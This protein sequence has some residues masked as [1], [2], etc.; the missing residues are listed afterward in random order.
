MEFK[1]KLQNLRKQMN[2]TQEQLASLLYISRTAV[3]KWE[4]GKGYPN[5]DSLK[6]ISKL[7]NVTINDLLS[8]EEIVVATDLEKKQMNQQ[9]TIYIFIM[10]NFFSAL[11]AFVPI[12]SNYV[13]DVYVFVNLFN[14]DSFIDIKLI[15]SGF[16]ILAFI[17]IFL[18][19]IVLYYRKSLTRHVLMID[20]I[21]F[22]FWTLFT[23][24]N[25]QPY[26]GS[27][28]FLFLIV[29]IILIIKNKVM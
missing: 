19:I 8:T 12:F 17:F 2:M 22:I 10:L 14:Y 29:K 3:S 15:L 6:E 7:F 24:L 1:D 5:L 27:F 21:F 4:T 28:I 13:N 23:I 9:Y 11:L 18:H 16:F 26:L 20:S 25:R